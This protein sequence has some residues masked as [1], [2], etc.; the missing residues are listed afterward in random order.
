MGLDDNDNQDVSVEVPQTAKPFVIVSH[1]PACS[2]GGGG[3]AVSSIAVACN[4]YGDETYLFTA[5]DGSSDIQQWSTDVANAVTWKRLL[6]GPH[7]PGATLRALKVLESTEEDSALSLLLLSA[8]GNSLAIWDVVTG[9]LLGRRF[10]EPRDDDRDDA[11]SS[12]SNVSATNTIT[13]VDT[14]GIHVYVGTET[15]H[16]VAYTVKDLCQSIPSTA[17]QWRAAS[18]PVTTI[19]CGGPGTLGRGGSAPTTV[20]YTGDAQGTVKQWEIF[21][22]DSGQKIEPWPKLTTQRMPKKAHLFPGTMVP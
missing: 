19:T 9:N 18:C 22:R 16:V 10:V 20:L 5:A 2:H 11:A 4:E 12:T 8:D 21:A 15:G 1:M 3:G 7:H 17:G 6:T 14:D 13:C